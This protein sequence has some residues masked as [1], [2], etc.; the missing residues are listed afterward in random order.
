MSIKNAWK[1]TKLSVSDFYSNNSF[2]LSASLAYFTVFSLPGLLIIVIWVS[3]MFYGKEIVEGTLYRQLEGFIGHP[4]AIGVQQAIRNAT[5][6]S[7]SGFATV[8]GIVSLVI[9]ATSVFGEIQDSINHIW[10]LRAKRKGAGLLKIVLNRLLS[11]SMIITLGFILMV[12]L[13]VNGAMDMVLNNLVAKYPHLTVAL[14]YI[15]NLIFTFLMAMLIFAAIF[16]VLPDARIEWRHVWRGSLVTAILFLVG[17][18]LISYYL[19][20]SRMTN[21]YGTAGSVIVIL[22]WVYYSAM[23]LYFGAAFTHA[24][25]LFKGAKIYPNSYAVWVQQLEVESDNSI[26]LQPKDK[27]V[28]EKK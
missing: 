20:H 13:F 27:T 2:K 18:Y 5:L 9:G 24:Y 4:A 8:I 6:G 15:I 28:V 3:D 14:I 16:K 26:Q 22:L 11:F 1:L 19:V 7:S 10:K 17:K 23:I 25:V 12:S 21:A